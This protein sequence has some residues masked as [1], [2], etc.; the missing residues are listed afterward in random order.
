MKASRISR[1]SLRTGV[2]DRIP[3]VPAFGWLVAST[4]ARNGIYFLQ[5][6]GQVLSIHFHDFKSGR[7]TLLATLPKE[8]SIPI[9]GGLAISPDGHSLLY[10]QV[11]EQNSDI[12]LVEN[13]R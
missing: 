8:K 7:T 11:D 13:F 10:S 3:G 5:S 12:M 4:L 9:V 2:A 6:D 1:V